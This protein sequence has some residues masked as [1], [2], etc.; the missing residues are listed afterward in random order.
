MLGCGTWT[1]YLAERGGE[2]LVDEI[3][4]SRLSV[5]YVL[6]GE[7]SADVTL[8]SSADRWARCCQMLSAVEPYRHEV[9]LY[10]GQQ[11]AFAGPVIQVI[12][13]RGN[14][15]IVAADLY[16]WMTKRFLDTDFFASDDLADIFASLAEL[17][18]AV[19]PTINLDVAFR[20]VGITGDRRLSGV[21]FP[22]I[23]DT[24]EELARTAVDFTVR[25]RTLLAGRVDALLDQR[26]LIVHDQ[27]VVS[28][29]VTRDGR[30]FATDVA[31]FGSTP[32]GQTQ[33]VFGR[34]TRQATTYGV[35][36]DS[37]AELLIGDYPTAEVNAAS[38]LDAMQPAPVRV[39]CEL[40]EDAAFDF[41]SLVPGALADVGLTEAA[42]CVPVSEGMRLVR[43][44]V[45]ASASGPTERISTSFVPVGA[46]G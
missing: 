38:R 34:A 8:N 21:T 19:D 37:V 39:E 40:S 2:V 27:G 6:N 10:R 23:S 20:E 46:D 3:D 1:A 14:A 45:E 4:A 17:A 35:V 16:H 24:L 30:G 43:V 11:L 12:S 7:G 5:N 36:Q 26:P 44:G 18:V 22:R 28:A 13:G 32:Q 15:R 25:G 9:H 33:P 42:G 31:V 29:Q 41:E